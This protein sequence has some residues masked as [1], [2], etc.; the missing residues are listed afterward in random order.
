MIPRTAPDSAPTC[1]RCGEPFPDEH[2]LAL[3]RGH[4]H[5]DLTPTERSAFEDAREAE[6]GSLRLFRLQALGALVLLYFG[7][8][9]AYAV[10]T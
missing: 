9:M 7:F 10:V 3:H 5:E 2:L 4:A 6:T 1:D 8:L